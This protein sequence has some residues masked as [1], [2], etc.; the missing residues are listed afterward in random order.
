ML[1]CAGA[2]VS[3]RPAAGSADLLR[4]DVI[5][6]IIAT[7]ITPLAAT[8][9]AQRQEVVGRFWRWSLGVSLPLLLASIYVFVLWPGGREWLM[10][11]MIIAAMGALF[12]SYA[13]V[14]RFQAEGAQQLLQQLLPAYSGITWQSGGM[15]LAPFDKSGLLPDYDT[16]ECDDY[17][18]GAWQGVALD[19]GE[20]HLRR[21]EER[22]DSKGRRRQEYV[23]VYRGLLARFACHKK[24]VGRTILARD[25][26]LF[27]F[28]HS[29][30]FAGQ[31]VVLEDPEFEQLFQVFGTDQ[32]EARY[33]LTTAF[34]QR[35]KDLSKVWKKL[36]AAF[37][38]GHLLLALPDHRAYF[39]MGS[40]FRRLDFIA[41][42]RRFV[43]ELDLLLDIIATL[44]L[45][46]DIGF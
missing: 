15:S 46:Q 27:N 16:K 35:L 31:R 19:I 14:T 11:F 1:F 9:E 3:D 44:K 6:K 36:S 26:G 24:F 42:A 25:A 5:E 22:I 37:I 33:L 28:L 32:I 20:W 45:E 18:H 7:Q 39:A 12:W 17:F 29:F 10:P 43:Q 23:T 38:D 21:I 4:Q 13:K 8:L 30:A 34:M 2:P 40:A 41:E